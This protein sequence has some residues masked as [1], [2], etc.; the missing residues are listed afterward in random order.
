MPRVELGVGRTLQGGSVIPELGGSGEVFATEH[1]LLGHYLR[2]E[3]SLWSCDFTSLPPP[4]FQLPDAS[5]SEAVQEVSSP[6]QA[7]LYTSLIKM[8]AFSPP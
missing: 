3:G 4:F 2:Q 8:H 5:L 6:P 7:L 1:T